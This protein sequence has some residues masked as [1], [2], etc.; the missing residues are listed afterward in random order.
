MWKIVCTYSCIVDVRKVKVSSKL[1]SVCAASSSSS[2]SPMLVDEKL[3]N[4]TCELSALVFEVVMCAIISN[5]SS[6]KKIV[7]DY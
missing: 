5:F 1:F 3:L 7:K 4:K 2:Y 6:F